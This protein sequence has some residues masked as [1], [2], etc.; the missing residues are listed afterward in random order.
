MPS[1]A[2]FGSYRLRVEGSL[3]KEAT[4]NIFMNETDIEFSAKQA[5]LFIQMS[6]P[7]YRQGQR[8]GNFQL[9]EKPWVGM[10][11]GIFKMKPQAPFKS[12]N[13]QI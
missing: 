5:S 1:N 11:L 3:D 2:Q 7:I 6:Q 4:G 13:F 8:G 10:V 12:L 9:E